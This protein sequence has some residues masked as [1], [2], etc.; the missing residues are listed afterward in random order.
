MP[1][2]WSKPGQFLKTLCSPE[3]VKIY[4]TKVYKD[5]ALLTL[6]NSLKMLCLKKSFESRLFKMIKSLTDRVRPFLLDLEQTQR[7]KS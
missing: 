3:A 5:Y 1:T 2:L 7:G 6:I 4:I